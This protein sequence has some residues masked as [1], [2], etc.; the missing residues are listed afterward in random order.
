MTDYCM[1]VRDSKNPEGWQE[2]VMLEVPTTQ[3]HKRQWVKKTMDDPVAAAKAI[4]DFFNA[5]LQGDERPRQVTKV[6]E[7]SETG[8]QKELW[9]GLH[10]AEISP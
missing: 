10:P 1:L 9:S 8:E 4:I 6:F 2:T 7:Q 5:T 3:R